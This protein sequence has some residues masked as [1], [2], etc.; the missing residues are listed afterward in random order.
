M[1][2]TFIRRRRVRAVAPA[3]LPSS[4]VPTPPTTP[5]PSMAALEEET[6]S[7]CGVCGAF[8]VFQCCGLSHWI[9]APCRVAYTRA[10]EKLG[11]SEKL[12]CPV[13]ECMAPFILSSEEPK[14]RPRPA[15]MEKVVSSD[16][17]YKT[18]LD[19]FG[20]TLKREWVTDIFRVSNPP[21]Q[22][23]F[24]AC[25]ARM[26]KEGR[27]IKK[28]RGIQV[29]VGANEQLC[30]HSTSRAASGSIVRS[31]FDVSR[32]GSAFGTALGI[33]I[34]VSPYASFSHGYSKEDSSSKRCMILC[35]VL[36][37]DTTGRDSISDS[38]PNQYCIK[39]EQQVL[40][41]FVLHYQ[42]DK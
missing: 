28:D 33:G 17:T 20:K 2:T 7:Q 40:P 11:I 41:Q 8:E 39:R 32:A 37:G 3:S 5:T 6:E 42:T 29:D 9:C 22:M 27:L 35:R 25:K 4:M 36:L 31:G 10:F 12:V 30:W 24:E 34:Y 18:V 1:N 21:M 14:M 23:L 13:I 19:L 15:R 16:P 38:V 26:E